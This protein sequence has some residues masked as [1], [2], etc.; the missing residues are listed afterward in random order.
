MLLAASVEYF[1]AKEEFISLSDKKKALENV[2]A[3]LKKEVEKR[4]K[5]LRSR[6]NAMFRRTKTPVH[7]KSASLDMKD[8]AA[9]LAGGGVA[10]GVPERGRE[11]SGSTSKG[12]NKKFGGTKGKTKRG[13][14]T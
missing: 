4:K 8:T 1:D 12:R 2:Y 6:L 13:D 9:V 3:T 14:E 7:D 10:L 5:K 11:R